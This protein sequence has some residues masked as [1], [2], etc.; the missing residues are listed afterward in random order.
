MEI[1]KVL[2]ADRAEDFS[3]ALAD[4]LREDFQV[5]ICRDGKTAL[6]LLQSFAPDVLVVDLILT[7][8]DGISLLQHAAA[9]GHL[10]K[11][12]AVSSLLSSYIEESMQELGVGYLVRKPCDLK[13]TARIVREMAFRQPTVHTSRLDV[14]SEVSD[15]LLHLQ[16]DVSRD[17]YSRLCA[18]IRYR[19]GHPSGLLTKEVYPAVAKQF[20]CSCS[21]V[22]KSISRVIE[23]AWKCRDEAAWREFFPV[24]HGGEL[25]RPTND[26]FISRLAVYLENRRVGF[27]ED[28]VE[29]QQIHA[30]AGDCVDVCNKI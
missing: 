12:L 8:L 30:D 4:L 17:G 11:V 22:E 28:R 2:I 1:L 26:K 21:Q 5:Q 3:D 6:A 14:N 13:A 18:A 16:I 24:E 29:P 25:K 23:A 27:C 9:L 10:P 20:N 19:V 7:E 15:M